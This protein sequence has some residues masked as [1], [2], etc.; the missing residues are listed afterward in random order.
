MIESAELWSTQIAC[1]NDTTEIRYGFEELKRLVGQRRAAT[2]EPALGA[3]F[4]RL[5]EVLSAPHLETAGVFVSCFSEQGD[6]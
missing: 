1:L 5:E 6:D 3:L 4:E 2:K